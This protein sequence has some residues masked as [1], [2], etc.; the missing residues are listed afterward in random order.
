MQ[1]LGKCAGHC[2]K[3]RS[4]DDKSKAKTFLRKKINNKKKGKDGWG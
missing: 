3:M 2:E 1:T 4:K